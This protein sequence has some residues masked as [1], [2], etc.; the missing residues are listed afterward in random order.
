MVNDSNKQPHPTQ[1]EPISGY[2]FPVT[3]EQNS[4]AADRLAESAA[5]V[6]RLR[7]PNGCHWDRE[8]TF[9][10]LKRS[11]LE[12]TYEV[13]DAIERR[14]WQHL[15][16]ELGDYLLQGIFYSQMASEAGHFNLADVLSILNEKLVRRHPHVFAGAEATD[17]NAVLRNWEIV[18]RQEKAEKAQSNA[19]PAGMLDDVG[20]AMPAMLEAHKLGS[21]AAKVGFDW[22]DAP[23]VLDKLAEELSELR[24][25]L[26]ANDQ[27]HAEEELGD[28][29]FAL[30]SLARHL[31]VD[32][33][34][35]LRNANAKFRRRFAKMEQIRA[36]QT[37]SPDLTGLDA[38]ALESLWQQTKSLE[39]AE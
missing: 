8:Q 30:A 1:P 26:E 9:D 20:R 3:P 17:T 16:E 18:K 19:K 37:G 35:A 31:K 25:A 11:T 10:S 12:E 23:P 36:A 33:E 39:Q 21:R 5:I 14:D 15:K 27:A 2:E 4:A 28:L 7:A 22:P 6:A 24:H 38:A 34:F 32:T 29:L 13:F